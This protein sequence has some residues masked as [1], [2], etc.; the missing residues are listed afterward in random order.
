MRRFYSNRSI[1]AAVASYT[2]IFVWCGS[3]LLAESNPNRPVL[4][5]MDDAISKLH[6]FADK[7]QDLGT[8]ESTQA[9]MDAL[10]AT[11]ELP[12][13]LRE[14]LREAGYAGDPYESNRQG[15]HIL[16]YLHY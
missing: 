8:F 14:G 1:I 3:H 5:Q 4:A 13:A 12:N 15:W 2:S 6:A 9:A 7:M 10:D 11:L 16:E